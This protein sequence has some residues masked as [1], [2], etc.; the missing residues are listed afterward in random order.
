MD[1]YTQLSLFKICT[2]CKE[3]YPPTAEYFSRNKSKTDGF[4]SICKACTSKQQRDWRER[5]REYVLESK[6]NYY[7]SNREYNLVKSKEWRENNAEYK[8]QKD[9]EY[10]QKNKKQVSARKLD[11]QNQNKDYVNAQKRRKYK[12]DPTGRKLSAIRRE[13]RKL[14]LPDTLTAEEWLNCLSY[15]DNKCAVCGSSETLHADHWI[16]LNHSDCKGTVSDN[17]VPLCKSCNCS[18]QDT[19]PLDWLNWKYGEEMATNHLQ[20]IERYF[21]SLKVFK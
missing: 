16:P 4:E 6:R 13:A 1:K 8:K 18:K 21:T 10:A 11:W 2:K 19:L 12:D 7:H 14:E 15:F 9:R 17:I 20:H 3:H 5:N